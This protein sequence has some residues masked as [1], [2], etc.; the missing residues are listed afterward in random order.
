[1]QNL[2]SLHVTLRPDYICCR[3]LNGERAEIFLESVI[4]VTT[5]DTFV[6]TLPFPW[7]DGTEQHMKFP[8][9]RI[10]GSPDKDPWDELLCTIR[11]IEL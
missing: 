4:K 5:P 8:R 1:M 11:H 7:I 3:N 9:A 6:L 10:P 2:L